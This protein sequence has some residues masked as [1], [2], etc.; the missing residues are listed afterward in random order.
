MSAFSWSADEEAGS[1]RVGTHF[2]PS[3]CVSGAHPLWVCQPGIIERRPRRNTSCTFR[4]GRVRE[5]FWQPLW[6]LAPAP[7]VGFCPFDYSSFVRESKTRNRSTGNTWEGRS[8]MTQ[9]G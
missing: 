7:G 2:S 6:L 4:D 9:V 5:W 1:L 8:C 3:R